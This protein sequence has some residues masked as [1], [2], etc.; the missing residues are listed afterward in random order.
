MPRHPDQSNLSEQQSKDYNT[1]YHNIYAD[2]NLT[3]RLPHEPHSIRAQAQQIN[4]NDWIVR[5]THGPHDERDT[6]GSYY[7]TVDT[8]VLHGVTPSKIKTHVRRAAKGAHNDLLKQ[9]P[10]DAS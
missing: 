1:G 9:R 3:D 10:R 8:K 2:L 4:R 7:R 5:T 6:T